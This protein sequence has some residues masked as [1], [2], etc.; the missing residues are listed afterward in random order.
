MHR[1]RHILLKNGKEQYMPGYFK[2]T[3]TKEESGNIHEDI[4]IMVKLAEIFMQDNL[5][6]PEEKL[7][8]TELIRKDDTV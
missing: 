5:I 8:L 7:R 2:Q 3:I 6:S 4:K 1:T